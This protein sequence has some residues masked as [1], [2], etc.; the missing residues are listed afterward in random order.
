MSSDR[1][2]PRPC[3]K[4]EGG[5]RRREGGKQEGGAHSQTLTSRVLKYITLNKHQIFTK[6][7]YFANCTR[8]LLG[9]G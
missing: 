4:G 9:Q 2:L 1:L 5:C 8:E 6:Q 7:G 3:A